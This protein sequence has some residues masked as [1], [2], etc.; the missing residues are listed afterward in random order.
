MS[1]V[2]TL[3]LLLAFTGLP[4][5][6]SAAPVIFAGLAPVGTDAF[7]MAGVGDPTE[8][9]EFA[10]RPG[11]QVC[12]DTLTPFDCSAP[13]SGGAVVGALVLTPLLL[14]G[15]DP[16]DP[17]ALQFEADPALGPAVFTIT[18]PGELTPRVQATIETLSFRVPTLELAG[19]AL[20]TPLTLAGTGLANPGSILF[21]LA[22]VDPGSDPTA[23]TRF[24]LVGGSL[25]AD[26]PGTT[27]PEPATLGLLAVGLS[28]LLGRR[29]RS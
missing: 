12:L 14:T 15:V 29:R 5:S 28:A 9:V 20:F 7:H 13:G 18:V 25:S 27:V 10:S 23:L 21:T 6:I 1:R 2:R 3:A 19:T 11:A 8:Y 16:L 24:Q 26:V 22:L 17:S 4:A